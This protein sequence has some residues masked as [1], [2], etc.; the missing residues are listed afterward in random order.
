MKSHPKPSDGKF[1][2]RSAI[3]CMSLENM[4]A[5]FD[6]LREVYNEFDFEDHPEAIYNMDGREFH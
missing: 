6:L 1:N 5:Y 3:G 4:K 2:N